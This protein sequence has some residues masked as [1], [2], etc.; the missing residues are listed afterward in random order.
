MYG[1]RRASG[2]FVGSLVHGWWISTFVDS[3]L[4]SYSIFFNG[5]V[6]GIILRTK[7]F[8]YINWF[9]CRIITWRLLRSWWSGSLDLGSLIAIDNSRGSV[10]VPSQTHLRHWTLFHVPSICTFQNS[11]EC[12]LPLPLPSL[13]WLNYVKF[14]TTIVNLITN[15]IG[16]LW[17]ENNSIAGKNIISCVTSSSSIGHWFLAALLSFIARTSLGYHAIC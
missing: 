5:G 17:T 16:C 15:Y 12:T 10:H 6:L 1:R 11:W 4:S 2:T 7:C 3:S 8:W 14:S 9:N 13:G